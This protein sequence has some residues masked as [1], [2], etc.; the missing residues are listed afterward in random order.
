M[1]GKKKDES[2]TAMDRFVDQPGQV[3]NITPASV[4]KRQEKAM[5]DFLRQNDEAPK[6]SRR[7]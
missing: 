1:A 6:K 7:K 5:E 4:R 3:I 2:K